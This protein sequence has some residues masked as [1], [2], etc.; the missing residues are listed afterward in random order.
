M[1]HEEFETLLDP[2]LSQQSDLR[3]ILTKTKKRKYS[4]VSASEHSQCSDRTT[5]WE[6]KKYNKYNDFNDD[7][8]NDDIPRSSTQAK[9][10]KSCDVLQDFSLIEDQTLNDVSLFDSSA[11]ELNIIDDHTF[12]YNQEINPTVLEN[13]EILDFEAVQPALNMKELMLPKLNQMEPMKRK[14]K[15]RKFRFVDKLLKMPVKKNLSASFDQYQ[16]HHMEDLPRVNFDQ[17]IYHHKF[18]VDVLFQTAVRSNISPHLLKQLKRHLK[19]IPQ[20]VLNKKSPKIDIIQ[21]STPISKR[22]T[23]K[24]P[25]LVKCSDETN[26][27]TILEM[28]LPQV[29]SQMLKSARVALWMEDEVDIIEPETIIKPITRNTVVDEYDEE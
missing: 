16:K 29:E 19:K 7:V 2:D 26:N 11:N 28:E 12:I 15:Q 17:M 24:N 5:I 25:T 3:T 10:T 13:T 1:T 20:T 23:R 14:Q 27:N 6:E 4:E 8:F 9:R 18:G 21:E 22:C